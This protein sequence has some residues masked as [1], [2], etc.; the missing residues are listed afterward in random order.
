MSIS[1]NNLVPLSEA[2]SAY[3]PPPLS[4]KLENEKR[5]LEDRLSKI[6]KVLETLNNEPGLKKVMDDISSLGHIH[7]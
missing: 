5:T 2:G 4:T 7:Y 1:N 3:A 6:N